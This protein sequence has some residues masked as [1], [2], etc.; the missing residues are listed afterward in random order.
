MKVFYPPVWPFRVGQKFGQN[1]A[2]IPITGYKPGTLISCDGHN[3]PPGYKSVYGPEGHTG[4]D[5]G[6]NHSQPV[7]CTY[8]GVVYKVDSNE[9]TGLDVRIESEIN[10]IRYRHIYEHLLG[11]QYKVGDKVELGALIGWADNTGY[12]SGDHL[13]YQLEELKEGKWT[14]IDP[15]PLM[16]T[17]ISALQAASIYRQIKELLARMADILADYV[18]K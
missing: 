4:I 15:M 1:Q 10:G 6:A 2:C 7:Y 17:H 11:Y 18:R 3:P 13:H 14:P 9:R 16:Y 12:S 8:P 5:V